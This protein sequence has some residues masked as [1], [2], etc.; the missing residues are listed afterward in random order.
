LLISPLPPANNTTVF[1]VPDMAGSGTSSNPYIIM[2]ASDLNDVRNNLSAF[3]KFRDYKPVRRLAV[4]RKKRLAVY[5]RPRWKYI[6]NE[7]RVDTVLKLNP[8]Q[9]LNREGLNEP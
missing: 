9:I 4:N 8:Y 3:N 1:A 6:S 5:R 7:I 2:N